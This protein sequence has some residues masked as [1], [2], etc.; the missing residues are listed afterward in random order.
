MSILGRSGSRQFHDEDFSCPQCGIPLLTAKSTCPK[1]GH[2]PSQGS[3]SA[4]VPRDELDEPPPTRQ[5]RTFN[6]PAAL[7]P[8][9]LNDDALTGS[10]LFV[11]GMGLLFGLLNLFIGPGGIEDMWRSMVLIA[12]SFALLALRRLIK[13]AS[14][15]PE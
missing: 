15:K 6:R 10:L 12:I 9:K 14:Q 7:N 5:P 3:A 4:Q 13:L 1:C 8:K 2:K 11:F